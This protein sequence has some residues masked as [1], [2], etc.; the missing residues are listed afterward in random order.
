LRREAQLV[1]DGN[2]D[3]PVADVEGEVARVRGGFQ[4]LAPG[5]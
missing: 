2:T 4:L 5:F 1:G 3:A